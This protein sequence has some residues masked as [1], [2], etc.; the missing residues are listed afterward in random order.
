M[1]QPTYNA[2]TV[3]TATGLNAGAVAG[4]SD[5]E[6][7][8]IVNCSY[9]T[10]VQPGPGEM[11]DVTGMPTATLVADN[12][13][14]GTDEWTYSENGYP[15]LTQFAGTDVAYLSAAALLLADGGDYLNVTSDFKLTTDGILCCH[16]LKW[17]Q[18]RC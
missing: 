13:I 3:Y 17:Q 7:D 15:V 18:S 5:N 11:E 2:G 10:Q 9:D 8:I 1:S 14:L 12:E 6:A 4:R 16:G